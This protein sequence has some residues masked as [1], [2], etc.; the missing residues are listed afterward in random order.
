MCVCD[1]LIY[2]SSIYSGKGNG[3]PFQYSWLENSKDGGGWQAIVHGVAEQHTTE[4][5]HS[6]SLSMYIYTNIQLNIHTQTQ[7]PTLIDHLIC[8]SVYLLSIHLNKESIPPGPIKQLRFVLTSSLPTY[9]FSFSNS[10]KSDTSYL[11]YISM[12]A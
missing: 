2:I 9:V 10:E 7:L 1:L 6:L 11:Q 5:L 4:R 3:N 8:F 12:F